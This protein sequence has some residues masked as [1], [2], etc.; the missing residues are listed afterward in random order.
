MTLKGFPL[1]GHRGG[2]PRRTRRVSIDRVTATARWRWPT[3]SR[4]PRPGSSEIDADASLR[5]VLGDVLD[6]FGPTDFVGREEVGDQGGWSR[7]G[8]RRRQ[9]SSS[10]APRSTPRA[11]A[12]SATPG[13]ITTD[14]RQ[15]RGARHHRTPCPACN[16]HRV[17]VVEGTIEPGPGGDGGHRRRAPRRHPPQPHRHPRPALGPAQGARRRA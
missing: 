5:L 2:A 14:T 12:R 13:S 8:D 11:A 10:T 9:H 16:R 4:S 1:G 3:P 17:R 6:R 7:R 15:G